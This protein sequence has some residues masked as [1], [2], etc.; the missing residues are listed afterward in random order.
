METQ[1][2][3]FK[4]IKRN[5]HLFDAKE[6]VLGRLASKIASLLL[7]KNKIYFTPHLDC[8]DWVVVINSNQIKVT[9]RKEKQKLYRHH[10]GYPQGFRELTLAQV[11]AKDS[12]KLISLAV[13]KM[14]PKNKLRAS[15]LKRL[16]I[17]VDDKH[18]Y[19]NKFK[20]KNAEKVN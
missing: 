14:L 10:T 16:R 3:K 18:P 12:R 2:T 6:E 13:A 7:G 4:D 8:G 5:W 17:F 9:G 11:R 15:R 20:E 19:T 1:V